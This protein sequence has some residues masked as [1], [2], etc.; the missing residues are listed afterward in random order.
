M[1]M[2]NCPE[3][4]GQV[5]DSA[6]TCP[7]CGKKLN[8]TGATKALMFMG[9]LAL[10]V[11]GVVVARAILMDPKESNDLYAIELCEKPLH[12]PYLTRDVENIVRPVCE[13]MKDTFRQKYGYRPR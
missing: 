6:I 9:L 12:D 5:S 13:S 2:I 8:S 7:H 3:C 4:Q 11:L 10:L 1:A